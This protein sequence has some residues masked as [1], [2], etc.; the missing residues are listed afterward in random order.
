MKKLALILAIVFVCLAFC[1]CGK[2]FST[3]VFDENGIYAEYSS[4][5]AEEQEKFLSEAEEEGYALGMDNEGR[6]T[7]K[8]DGKTYVLGESKAAK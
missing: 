5:S 6:I 8:K 2:T 1:A 4:L 3:K 7:L